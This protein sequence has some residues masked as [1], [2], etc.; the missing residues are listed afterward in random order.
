MTIQAPA[1]AVARRELVVVA[2]TLAALARLVPRGDAF[3]VA[4]L[5]FFAVLIA[6]VTALRAGGRIPVE[7]L[8]VPALLTAGT[9]AALQLVPAGLGLVPAPALFAFWGAPVPALPS[10]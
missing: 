2:V 8:L 1:A 9:G 4:L 6:G 5:L 7:S 3:V 10:P